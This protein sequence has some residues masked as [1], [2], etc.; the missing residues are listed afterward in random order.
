MEVPKLLTPEETAELLG[1]AVD[2]LTVW[3]CTGRVVLPWVKVGRLV[4][5]SPLA[6]ARFCAERTHGAE[7]QTQV[8]VG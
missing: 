7:V 1:V 3:R 5:Y 2:T 4:R 6:V 8:A